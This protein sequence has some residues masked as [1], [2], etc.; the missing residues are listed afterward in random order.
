MTELR[1]EDYLIPSASIG[2]ENPLPPLAE[3]A[4]VHSKIPMDDS[5]SEEE[6]KYIGYGKIPCILPYRMQDGYDRE[7]KPRA[8]HAAVLENE[9]L[10][11]VFLPE[12][13]GRL[14]SL[15]DKHEN[16]EL[17]HRNPVFQP[18]NLALR[19]AWF[20][21]GVEWNIGMTGHHPFTCSEMFT[22]RVTLNDGTPVLRMYEWERVREASYSIEAYLPADSRFL[23][24]RMCIRNTQD[25]EIPMYWWSNMAVNEGEDVRVLVPADHAFQFGYGP[26]LAKVPVPYL[27]GVDI[28]HSTQFK[29]AVDYFFD[30]PKQ[31]RKWIS[32][33]DGSGTGI[34][35][36]ST[37]RLIGRKLFVWGQG[38]GG[39]RWQSF[40]SKPGSR[41]IE[42]QSGLAHTQM[43]CIPMPANACWDWLEAY[44]RMDA[45][46]A[47]THGKD[48]EKAW[49]DVDTRLEKLLPDQWMEQELVRLRREL[50]SRAADVVLR[51]GSGWAALEQLR[52]N[53]AGE[54]MDV[55]AV[56]YSGSIGPAEEPWLTLL[57][58][59]VLPCP[60]P[61][62]APAS[63]MIA[64][65]WRALVE[66]S[67]KAAAG[68]HW[69]SWLQ[70]GIMR[71][72][73]GETDGAEEA[74]NRSMEKTP[75]PWALRNLAVVCRI[76]GDLQG[77]CDRMLRAVRM[78]PDCEKLTVECGQTLIKGGRFREAAEMLETAPESFRENGRIRFLW[79]EA[80]LG[81]GDHRTV[82][83]TL[84][85]G[86]TVDDMRE[87]EVSLSDLW[88]RAQC[89]RLVTE[90]G[91]EEN[92]AL[93]ARVEAE[94]PPPGQIDFRMKI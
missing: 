89:M 70:L 85:K 82:I 50:D 58:T 14:W 66:S 13:G 36:T 45:D 33:L 10:I 43:E 7:K 16:R 62:G 63:Y 67:V 15:V 84:N 29:N 18:A 64:P 9:H 8:F 26:G 47:V 77:A 40:L 52:R 37:S 59:G 94:F 57:K 65:E 1:F 80:K 31:Q 24:V 81:V 79:A 92:D 42:I 20:S 60:D 3:Q 4:D 49:Q 61:A 91:A 23:L 28:S 76:R 69:F 35:Q 19:N 27:D 54:R 75:S 48:W 88:F 55:G 12:L 68:D 71:F 25:K 32:A 53:A 44:G 51:K 86:I 83:D 78:Q 46:P 56:D 17:L 5:V 6:A 39:Q 30:V 11:A 90:E 21:G 34:V 72:Y 93:R 22:A 2:P 87:G 73:A 74:W 38:P 41:Y